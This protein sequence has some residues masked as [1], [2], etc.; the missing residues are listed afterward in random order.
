MT[1]TPEC[2][3]PAAATKKPRVDDTVAIHVP[4]EPSKAYEQQSLEL[5]NYYVS[6]HFKQHNFGF[7]STFELL[8]TLYHI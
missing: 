3:M 4:K 1:T 6:R 5:L 8:F 2:K 7:I